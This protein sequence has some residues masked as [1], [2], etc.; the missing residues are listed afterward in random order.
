MAH[1]DDPAMLLVV[2]AQPVLGVIGRASIGGEQESPERL[3]PVILVQSQRPAIAL[4]RVQGRP[5][6]SYQFWLIWMQ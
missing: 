6:K 3:L 2:P 1:R 5:V 4:N